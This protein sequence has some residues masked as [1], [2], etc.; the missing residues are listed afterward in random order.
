MSENK[1][2]WVA[3][4]PMD[5]EMLIP[6]CPNGCVARTPPTRNVQVLMLIL[7]CVY[8]HYNWHYNRCCHV[9]ILDIC[10][11]EGDEKRN[12]EFSFFNPHL[13]EPNRQMHQST[14][15]MTEH[16]PNFRLRARYTPLLD[17]SWWWHQSIV[18]QPKSHTRVENN[19]QR[20][21]YISSDADTLLDL[22]IACHRS[23]CTI[24]V[25]DPSWS[26][27][28]GRPCRRATFRDRYAVVTDI[29]R[30]QLSRN[31]YRFE[32]AECTS[33]TF[34]KGL[35]NILFFLEHFEFFVSITLYNM[36]P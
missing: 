34:G 28:A 3:A 21:F 20:S 25:P 8:V 30:F 10:Q 15:F 12:A 5:R 14:T 19:K 11:F 22:T 2:T 4:H 27:R 35:L 26:S 32:V 31:E 1:S 6:K 18:V 9:K 7:V 16:A 33:H 24:I 17:Y 23:S 36:C 29:A 13:L